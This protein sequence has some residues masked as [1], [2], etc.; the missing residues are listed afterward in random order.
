MSIN[1]TLFSKTFYLKNLELKKRISECDYKDSLNYIRSFNF[2]DN[3]KGN[4][5]DTIMLFINNLKTDFHCIYY[6]GEY[7][8]HSYELYCALD[9][10]LYGYE[11]TPKGKIINIFKCDDAFF[12][13]IFNLDSKEKVFDESMIYI[14]SFK[15]FANEI[16]LPRLSSI[17]ELNF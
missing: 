1:E 9:K 3:E 5:K 2:K 4:I 15:P 7:N 13:F 8:E 16:N 6:G 14:D 10:N 11:V 17:D 12:E